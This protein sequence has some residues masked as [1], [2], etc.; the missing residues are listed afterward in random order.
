MSDTIRV[1]LVG[2]PG[3]NPGRDGRANPTQIRLYQLKSTAKFAVADY[4]QLTSKE[5]T[6]LA[7]DLVARTDE[8]IRPGE[9]RE[10]SLPRRPGTT[11]LGVAASYRAIDT[12][13]WRVAVPAAEKITV[14]VGPNAVAAP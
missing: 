11:A 6:V 4:F 1:T 7:G 3:Q 14:T 13:T 10:I 9:T 8:T 5:D 12:A 2:T